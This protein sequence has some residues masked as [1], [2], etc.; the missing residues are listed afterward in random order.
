MTDVALP[1]VWSR[2]GLTEDEF[3]TVE[4]LEEIAGHTAVL[5]SL[6]LW[7]ELNTQLNRL[8]NIRIGVRVEAGEALDTLLD[9]LAHIDILVLDFPA[10]NDGRSFS[11]AARLRSHYGFAGEIR[12]SG[13]VHIDQ[14]SA[15]LRSG[16]DTLQVKDARTLQRLLTGELHDSGLYY[17]PVAGGIHG[18]EQGLA[19]YS[20]RRRQGL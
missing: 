10:F 1:A 2:S 8:R 11:K 19:G 6:T 7:A 16:F 15:M 20:W 5:L 14:V 3:V 4:T 9:D 13:A 12:A 17:Q 18:A